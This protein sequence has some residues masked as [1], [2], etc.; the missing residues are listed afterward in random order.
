M[1]DP[2]LCEECGR[3]LWLSGTETPWRDALW[4]SMTGRMNDCTR[5]QTRTRGAA[6]LGMVS[7]AVHTE[8]VLGICIQ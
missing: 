1:P 6:L 7:T 2:V 3:V 5:K 8:Q 4:P